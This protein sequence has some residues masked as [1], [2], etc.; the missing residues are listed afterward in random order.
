VSESGGV[1]IGGS[2]LFDKGVIV[3]ASL[4]RPYMP[5]LMAK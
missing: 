3:P 5:R 1:V 4:G 2:E